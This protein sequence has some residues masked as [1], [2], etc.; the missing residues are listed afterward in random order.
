MAVHWVVQNK[1]RNYLQQFHS[2]LSPF[3]LQVFFFFCNQCRL[4]ESPKAKLDQVINM[5]WFWLLYFAGGEYSW[6]W[7]VR[8]SNERDEK[9]LFYE[10]RRKSLKSV[11]SQCDAMLCSA[12]QCDTLQHQVIWVN[13][14]V[15]YK[16]LS[17]S[18]PLRFIHP[19]LLFCQH[20]SEP[21]LI[22]PLIIP[23]LLHLYSRQLT[24]TNT[25]FFNVQP[26]P[27]SFSTYRISTVHLKLSRKTIYSTWQVRVPFCPSQGLHTDPGLFSLQIPDSLQ[28]KSRPSVVWNNGLGKREKGEE[29][30]RVEVPIC[31]WQI[32]RWEWKNQSIKCGEYK[33]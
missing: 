2:S 24:L 32:L 20:H 14:S 23:L 22:I 12:A 10:C 25:Q 8:R 5:E 11:A 31:L 6:L 17:P 9:R 4:L 16:S 27:F 33:F 18:F 28:E 30:V 1:C 19:I 7:L 26:D 15:C 13:L 3:L 29:T 21:S